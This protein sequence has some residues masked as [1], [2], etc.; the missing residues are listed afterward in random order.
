MKLPEPSPAPTIGYTLRN[1]GTLTTGA[2]GAAALFIRASTSAFN[3]YRN[4]TLAGTNFPAETQTNIAVGTHPTFVERARVVSSGIRFWPIHAMTASTG[5]MSVVPINDDDALFDG[6]VHSFA[7]L[8]STQGVCV[9]GLKEGAFISAPLENEYT[10]YKP[11]SNNIT[12]TGNDQD[13][14]SVL[15]L[16]EGSASTLYLGWEVVT[17]YEGIVSAT[18]GSA[19]G[20][21]QA[22]T[23]MQKAQAVY[24]KVYANT[25]GGLHQGSRDKISALIK[26]KAM[27]YAKT[28]GRKALTYISPGAGALLQLTNG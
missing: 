17:H 18:S 3:I 6:V 4:Q 8:K 26:A 16:I 13:W 12:V 22:P 15:I 21:A 10:F 19:I 9:D 20:G 7:D 27:A 5:L 11:T 25:W 23:L 2:A 28:V 14:S 1:S 24:Q